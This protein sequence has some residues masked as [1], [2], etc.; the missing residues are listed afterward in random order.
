MTELTSRVPRPGKREDRLDEHRA[1]EQPG[2]QQAGSGDDGDQRVS[3]ARSAPSRALCSGPA[4]AGE[5]D[6]V[7]LELLEHR[8]AG[9]AHLEA[10][11]VQAEHE[12]GKRQVVQAATETQLP[13][14]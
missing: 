2:E 9:Q 12:R 14:P 10:H 4:R 3:V 5:G 7:L 11:P 8:G 1:R 13:G 6:V